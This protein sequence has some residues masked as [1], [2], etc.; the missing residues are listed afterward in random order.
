MST[1]RPIATGCA[2]IGL[3][4]AGVAA[5]APAYA[6][7]DGSRLK[8]IVEDI[9]AISRKSRDAG[10]KYWGRIAGSAANAEA[11]EYMASK[12]RAMGLQDVR[13]Q[14]FDLPPQWFPLE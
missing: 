10:I 4:V 2:I 11:T 9:A 8:Q 12:F 14:R 1:I 6:D 7:I 5:Q 13:F 3:A